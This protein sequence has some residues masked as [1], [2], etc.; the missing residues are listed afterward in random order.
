MSFNKATLLTGVIWLLWHT[1][2]ILFSDYRSATTP[3]WYSWMCFAIMIM[4]L[5]FAFNWLRAR[6]GSLWP[7]ALLHAS[8]NLWIQNMFDVITINTGVT[9]Y[10]I[11][12]FGAGLAI[13][14]IVLGILFS[15]LGRKPGSVRADS[16]DFSHPNP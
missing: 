15:L 14:G 10:L 16:L 1:P 4:G 11:G 5:T 8:H 12:E 2:L 7:S 3:I 9:A 13:V 6:S